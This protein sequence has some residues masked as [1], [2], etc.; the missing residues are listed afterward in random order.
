M[1]LKVNQAKNHPLRFKMVVFLIYSGLVYLGIA[2]LYWFVVFPINF[3]D[4]FLEESQLNKL[5]FLLNQVDEKDRIV[6]YIAVL[7]M[8][9]GLVI[10]LK[11]YYL[12][13]RSFDL[14]KTGIS[15]KK[16]ICSEDRQMIQC[17]N[18]AL[19]WLSSDQI[20]LRLGGI[21]ALERIAKVSAQDHWKIMEILSTFVR[22]QSPGKIHVEMQKQI[23]DSC[24]PLPITEDQ[25]LPIDIQ[26]ALTV[27]GRRDSS[28]ELEDDKIDLRHAT[29]IGANL[30]EA[31][32]QEAYLNGS[33]L[34]G[35]DLNQANLKGT[36]VIGAN[37]EGADCNQANLQGAYLIKANLTD[38]CLSDAN[39]E[40]AFLRSAKLEQAILW[41]ANLQRASLIQANLQ[42]ANLE[43][44]N[45]HGTD[46]RGANLQGAKNLTKK[47]IELAQIDSETILPYYLIRA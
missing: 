34:Q 47:Q 6:F 15:D 4:G 43:G 9:I 40:G 44:A 27:I 29:L 7:I 37:L 35:A 42:E 12:S 17:L 28:K 5:F 3:L 18:N 20:A 32:L 14:E 19:E 13:K 16:A 25:K 33:K 8:A 21:Y 41:N 11:I 10:L 1:K 38:A 23:N 31:N 30:T 46:L 45:L 36:Y 22:Y 26:G 24:S 2:S 39:L